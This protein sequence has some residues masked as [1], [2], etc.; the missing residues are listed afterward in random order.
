MIDED[1]W[2]TS[3]TNV[4]HRK[5]IKVLGSI[6]LCTNQNCKELTGGV[7]SM[8]IVHLIVCNEWMYRTSSIER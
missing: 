1:K 2:W 5:T 7:E 6:G 3:E 4:L 8:S